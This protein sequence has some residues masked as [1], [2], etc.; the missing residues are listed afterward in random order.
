MACTNS[1]LASAG[2]RPNDDPS[3][4]RRWGEAKIGF[5][6][7]GR[8]H[9]SGMVGHRLAQAQAQILTQ[10]QAVGAAPLRTTL[11]VDP[12]EIADQVD[13][14]VPARRQR[15]PAPLA[16]VVGRA[17]LFGEAIEPSLEQYCLQ[18]VVKGVA[19]RARQLSPAYDQISLPL[20]LPPQRHARPRPSRHQQISRTRFR[21]RADRRRF[22]VK[23]PMHP[24]VLFALSSCEG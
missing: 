7:R 15:R 11:A 3:N 22:V 8:P 1:A 5:A 21:Q 10:R 6:L 18:A 19:R 2:A 13:P 16:G 4:V 12:L 9:K 23:M 14:K 20:T 17:L 24:L